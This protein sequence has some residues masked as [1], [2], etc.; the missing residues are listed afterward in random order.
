MDDHYRAKAGRI[1]T[2]YEKS[3]SA[4]LSEEECAFPAEAGIMK[5]LGGNHGGFMPLWQIVRLKDNEI[6]KQ[7]IAIG[8]RVKG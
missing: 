4:V 7:L 3:Q 5:V 8:E 6:A 1:L 2:L